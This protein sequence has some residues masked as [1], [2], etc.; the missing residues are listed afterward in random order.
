MNR[1]EWDAD[2]DD[3]L[4]VLI[5]STLRAEFG[6]AR[7]A[8]ESWCRLQARIAFLE[9]ARAERTS[10]LT[11]LRRLLGNALHILDDN[12]LASEPHWSTTSHDRYF[13]AHERPM[14]PWSSPW[15]AY[16]QMMPIW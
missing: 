1:F 14:S 9:R 12:V 6:D 10:R 3:S 5:D 11:L 15:P 2:F 4:G 7:P 13:L 16:G 8:A